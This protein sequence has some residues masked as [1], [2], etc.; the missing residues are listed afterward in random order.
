[1]TAPSRP[2]APPPDL[3]SIEAS[4]AIHAEHYAAG[5][6]A[7]GEEVGG[8]ILAAI[9]SLV[10]RPPAPER[11]AFEGLVDALR[12]AAKD[13]G[14]CYGE[15][16]R[17]CR[18]DHPAK[19][20]AARAALL[21][22]IE[23]VHLYGETQRRKKERAWSER[24][25]AERAL[26]EARRLAIEEAIHVAETEEEVDGEIPEAVR[27]ATYRDPAGALRGVVRATKRG[28]VARLR[29]LAAASPGTTT[30]DPDARVKKGFRLG[31][32]AAAK[33]LEEPARLARLRAPSTFAGIETQGKIIAAI[34]ET[35]AEEIRKLA[36]AGP[37][38]S[39]AAAEAPGVRVP[40]S[41]VHAALAARD[42][43]AP[44]SPGSATDTNGSIEG[45]AR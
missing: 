22:A 3:A 10:A 23:E 35:E 19:I 37:A 43:R 41:D 34:L 44:E 20:A 25:S 17:V 28:I 6:Q 27:N 14:E 7:D 36:R 2:P 42:R 16:A 1:V 26:G 45:S 38:G 29:A 30:G 12:L 18:D 8:E 39:T 40:L 33:L 21:S 32:R 31:I 4:L 9:R 11:E 24:E 15:V 13:A 5:R